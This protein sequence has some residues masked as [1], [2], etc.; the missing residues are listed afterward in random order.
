MLRAPAE[1]DVFGQGLDVWDIRQEERGL[2][3]FIPAEIV[4]TRLL[5]LIFRL[6]RNLHYRNDHESSR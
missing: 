4:M 2:V 6:L 1:N 5:G 3:E